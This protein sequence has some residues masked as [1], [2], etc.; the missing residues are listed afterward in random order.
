MDLKLKV[1]H[2]INTANRFDAPRLADGVELIGEYQDSGFADPPYLAR[3]PDG[4]IIS[5]GRLLY[6][7][8]E[9]IDGERDP[10]EI[11]ARVSEAAGRRLAPGDV[12]YL[13]ERKLAPTG[14]LA[15]RRVRLTADPGGPLALRIRA[16]VVPEAVVR[17]LAFVLR[18]L[19]FPGVIGAVIAWLLTLDVWLVRGS[20]L[21]AAVRDIARN[22]ALLLFVFAA[23]V[24]G[25]IFH[26]LGHATACR[27]GGARP[28]VMGV[29]LYFIWPAFFT[30]V[31]DAYRLNRAG[32][33][34]TDLGGVYFNAVVA[35]V[36]AGVYFLTD[37]TPLLFVVAV[38]HFQ[39]AQ[40]LIPW[41][42]LDGYYVLTD[43]TG[44][45]DVLTRI[46]PILR[47]ALPWR[48]PEPEIRGLKTWVR[49]VVTVYVATLVP[50]L[51]A[52]YAFLLWHAPTF[53]AGAWS[54]GTRQLTLLSEGWARGD[55][56]AAALAAVQ[57]ACV[58]MPAVGMTLVLARTAQRIVA[59]FL[60]PLVGARVPR[61][62]VVG[63][64]G[65][66]TA[67]VAFGDAAPA[68][69]P[70]LDEP[71]RGTDPAT[72]T[73]ERTLQRSSSQRT[74]STPP[75]ATQS[76]TDD[77][78]VDPPPATGETDPAT[79]TRSSPQ[80]TAPSGTS[81]PPPEELPAEPPATEPVPTVTEPPPTTTPTPPTTTTPTTP[82]TP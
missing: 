70:T 35:L 66:V 16:A 22:P 75:A 63:V 55:L 57:L 28:G 54:A 56:P 49:T 26:E 78:S 53:F 15:G 58:A 20:H 71:K 33:L 62:A 37:F 69:A 2:G 40:Q 24:V 43:L 76:A 12:R 44:V 6:H 72:R 38:Q 74:V 39:I 50:L 45:P 17:A 1:T 79:T 5:V 25:T 73:Q 51:A 82:I 29:G 21:E 52:A 60:R 36:A 31:T 34:R 30:D 18:P 7:V 67:F 77:E 3:R 59:R 19:F 68:D 46:K 32:R 47:S 27:Y 41:M 9:Q 14:L 10:E 80:R 23:L 8:L 81:G 64:A 13:V 65:A 61:L 48:A 11:A 4:R 42:R